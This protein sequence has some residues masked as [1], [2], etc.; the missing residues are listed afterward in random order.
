M[1]RLRRCGGRQLGIG[2]HRNAADCYHVRMN[3]NP[4]PILQ[5]ANLHAQQMAAQA[6]LEGRLVAFPTDTV[7]GIGT[8]YDNIIGIA[9][10]FASKGRTGEKAIP[11]LIATL[12]Q[13]DALTERLPG[14]AV[15]LANYFWPGA[16][17]LILARRSGVPQELAPGRTTIGVRMPAH[18]L[19]RDLI[20]VTG[21]P[22]ACSSANLSGASPALSAAQV[23]A[24]FPVGLDFILDGGTTAIGTP[25]T[26]VDFTTPARPRLLREGAISRAALA[27]VLG[28]SLA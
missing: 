4:T 5:A 14:G 18:E 26:V 8:A 3:F 2:F 23:A 21:R 6:M 10:I 1:S 20:A 12:E 15:A 27:T 24:Y 19:T 11:I 28:A 9:R 17:T 7:Y 16:L 13:L 25:S 22:L